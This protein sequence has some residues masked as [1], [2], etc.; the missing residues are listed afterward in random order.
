MSDEFSKWQ[1]PLGRPEHK[2]PMEVKWKATH[3]SP[4]KKSENPY[5]AEADRDRMVFRVVMAVVLL[6]AIMVYILFFM[7]GKTK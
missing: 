5:K 4:N 3:G 7:T 2:K 1:R 6:A